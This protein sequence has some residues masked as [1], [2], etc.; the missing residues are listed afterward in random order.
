MD[1]S[2]SK[3]VTLTVPATQSKQQ[4]SEHADLT[5]P[6][7]HSLANLAGQL[8]PRSRRIYQ[9]D[10]AAFLWWLEQHQAGETPGRYQEREREP[11]P[12]AQ[13]DAA[14]L[15]AG[16]TRETVIAYRA[17]L[18][19]TYPKTTASRRLTVLRRLCAEA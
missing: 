9:T 2:P 1:E 4:M 8:A 10:V 5:V 16:L 6:F 7:Q 19:A 18:E 17:Y 3:V 13:A 14:L 11:M 15:L 12:L